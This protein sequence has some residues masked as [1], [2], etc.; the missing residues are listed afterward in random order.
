MIYELRT[1]KFREGMQD[2]L[3]ARFRDHTRAIFDRYG[4]TS[5]G[6]WVQTEPADGAGD[7]IYIVSHPSREAAAAAWEAFRADPEW[8]KVKTATE[9]DGPLHNG[10]VSQY[11][12]ATDFSA[13]K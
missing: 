13:I 2:R 4:I 1:Y 11:M 6:Y 3:L 12:E 7:L 5:I 10:V 8:V 9:T